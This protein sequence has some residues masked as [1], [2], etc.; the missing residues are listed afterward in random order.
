MPV[1]LDQFETQFNKLQ[2]A[3]GA[4]KPAKILEQWYNE[5][6]EEDYF[7]F[8]TAMRRCQY[9]QKFPT[10]EMF[11]AELRNARGVEVRE[12]FKGCGKCFGG[13]V[14][15]R[16]VAR[17]GKVSDQAGN[18]AKCSEGKRRDMASVHPDRLHIDAVDTLRTQRALKQD[19]A[20]GQ[21]IEEPRIREVEAPQ[22]MEL[23]KNIYGTADPANERKRYGSL[24]REE[25]REA[26]L[27]YDF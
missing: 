7:T 26:K 2:A 22:P 18:C 10:W 19:R 17:N 25:E 13:V 8:I 16:D 6:S 24:K 1:T 9:G 20:D 12:E 23:V 11:K 14:L 27:A 4:V 21:R 3:F 15:F 5:F